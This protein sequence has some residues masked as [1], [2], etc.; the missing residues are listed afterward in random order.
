MN[1]IQ[2]VST[3]QEVCEDYCYE[4]LVYTQGNKSA[5]ARILGITKVTLYRYLRRR[6]ERLAKHAEHT[7]GS[8]AE[9]IEAGAG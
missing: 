6:S 7:T 5:A 4:V 9:E 2:D 3:L 1:A 8:G